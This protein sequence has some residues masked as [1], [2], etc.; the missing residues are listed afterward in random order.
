[1][2]AGRAWGRLLQL[3]VAVL[4]EISVCAQKIP[5]FFSKKPVV[6]RAIAFKQSYILL[7]LS[8]NTFQGQVIN[9]SGMVATKLLRGRC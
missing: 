8:W 6:T 7:L 2:K 4:S 3:M 1:V 9:A 5:S